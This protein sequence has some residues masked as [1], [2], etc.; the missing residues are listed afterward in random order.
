MLDNARYDVQQYRQPRRIGYSSKMGIDNPVAT[1]GDKNM[2]IPALPDPHWPGNTA[3]RKRRRH[4][5]LR[6]REAER[7]DL[8]R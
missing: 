7:D 8:Y 1:I 2:A 3:F 6:G 5:S 4:G